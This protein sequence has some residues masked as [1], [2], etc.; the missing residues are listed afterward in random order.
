M[1][2]PAFSNY[3]EL[4][5]VD[6]MCITWT[7]DCMTDRR[8]ARCNFE[9]EVRRRTTKPRRIDVFRSQRESERALDDLD[10][11]GGKPSQTNSGFWTTKSD[12]FFFSSLRYRNLEFQMP[13]NEKKLIIFLQ[14]QFFKLTFRRLI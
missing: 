14:S 11:S 4:L 5:K 2:I 9:L 8:R 12:L 7:C 1:R 3:G 10:L 13:N 6:R